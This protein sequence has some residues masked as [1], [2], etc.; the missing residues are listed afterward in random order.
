[1]RRL[2]IFLLFV[3]FPL[4][5]VAQYSNDW[6]SHNQTYYKISVAATGVY[7]V[8][9]DQLQAAGVP[10]NSIDPRLI[11]LFHRG[12]EQ[13]IY[14]KHNQQPADQ[15]FESGE[16][17]EFYGER[18]D[19]EMDA[20][21]YRPASAQ[22]NKYSNLYSDSSA[23]FLTVN[24]FPVQ[25]KRMESSDLVNTGIAKE[26]FHN[27]EQL[28]VYRNEYAIGDVRDT[29]LVQS[30]YDYGEGWTGRTI[31]TQNGNCVEQ[32][33]YTIT[34]LSNVVTTQ[35]SPVLEIQLTGRDYLGHQVEIYAGPSTANLNLVTTKQFVN[36]ETPVYTQQVPW[37]YVGSDGRMIVRVK[38]LGVGGFRDRLSVAYIKVSFAQGF[39]MNSATS[40][41]F[42]LNTNA[43]SGGKAYIELEN[44][45]SGTRLWDITDKQEIKTIALK[46]SGSL[47]SA[48]I[49]NT[50]AAR[51]LYAS[52]QFM[53]PA[54]SQIK[55]VTF[56][57]LNLA[58]KFI[59]VTHKSLQQP[60]GGYSNPVRAFAEYRASAA[61][62]GYDTLTVNVDQLYDQF[63]YG[64]LSPVGIYEFMRYMVDKGS[65]QYL[66]L[67]GRGRE[68]YD[69]LNRRTPGLNEMPDLVPPAGSPGADMPYTA[70]L[71]G[72]PTYVP[73]VATG[74]LTA[75][76]PQEV[77]SYLDKVKESE[78]APFDALWR[79]SL[80]HL[81]GG[82]EQ[83]QITLF[84]GYM[85]G[86][87]DIAR[88]DYLG[89]T[90]KTI[91]KKGISEVE[92]INVSSEVNAGIN[93]VTFFGHS[94]PNVTDIDIGF[95][96]DQVLGY[97]NK[98]KYPAF[99]VNGCNAGNYFT[100]TETFGENWT[101]TANKGA[102]NFIAN[103]SFGYEVPLWVYAT[104]FYRVGFADS[105]FLA[106][107]I[108]DVQREVARRIMIDFGDGKSVYSA[109][110]Q[111]MVLLGDPSL[112]LFAAARPD[113]ETRDALVDVVS[114]DGKPIHA[115]TDSIQVQVIVN[116]L[117]RTTKQELT[118][119]LTHSINDAATDYLV[120]YPSVRSQDT[121]KFTIVRAGN[122][123]GNNKIDVFLDPDNKID[124]LNED[125]NKASWS[126]V[127]QFNG[128]QNLQPGNFSIVNSTSI[129]ALFQDT[130]VL[131]PEKT[132]NIEFD[133]TR[134]FNSPF[135]KVTTVTGKVLLKT[136]FDLLTRDST[137]Y[138]WR[139]KPTDKTDDEWATTS[140]TYIHNG[141]E[142]WTQMAFDQLLENSWNRLTANET[143]KKFE[144]ES[145]NVSFTVRTFGNQNTEANLTPS[146]TIN[147]AEYYYSPTTPCRDN[148]IN[149]VAFDRS[150]VAPYAAVFF[151]FSNSGGRACGREP[152]V[153]NS[154][155]AAEVETGNDDDLFAYINNLKQSDSVLLFTVGDPGF[156]SWSPALKAKLEEIGVSVSDIDSFLPG[157][158]I[159]ILGK[160]SYSPGQAK[161]IRSTEANPEEQKL[162][163]SEELTGY[164]TSG[165]I[166]SVTIGPSLAWHNM[167]PAY[168]LAD[169][170]D[171]AG[172]DVVLVDRFGQE[173][174]YYVQQT[175]AIDL[176]EIDAKEYPYMRLVYRT[177]DESHLTPAPLKNWLVSYDP[178]PDGLLV[179]AS[180]ITALQLPE[181]VTQTTDFAFINISKIDFI[182]SLQSV[183]TILNRPTRTKETHEFKIKGPLAGDTT[184]FSQ[185]VSTLGKV[186][187]NDLS[188]RVNTGFVPEQYLQNNSIELSSYLEVLRDRQN[189][190]LEVTVDGR[191]VNDGDFV[192]ANPVIRISLRDDN[193]LLA[194]RDTTSLN[195]FITY[196]CAADNCPAK[197]LVFSRSDVTWKVSDGDLVVVF[198]PKDLEEGEYVLMANGTDIAGNPSGVEPY[199]VSFVVDKD[200]G[201][202]FY[203]PYPNPSAVGFYFDFAAVG[204]Q[205][206]D[207]FSLTIINRA[208]Q[209][210][211]HFTDQDAPALRVGLNQLH[212]TGL[213]AQGSR[214][215]DGLYFY[216]LT[217]TTGGNTYKNAGRIMIIR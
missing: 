47:L 43:G 205:A 189:P 146:L 210:I 204:E 169:E 87:A 190:V 101:L 181:G 197:R 14:F 83:S 8:T 79:K 124:E 215:S 46:G 140:F 200:P 60:A 175:T 111:Q 41:F 135:A 131:S 162:Q 50:S 110:V 137:V 193:Q 202:I 121:L 24:P 2:R 188:A 209:D 198:N 186:G 114:F 125:N 10:V 61:G 72:N 168:K 107:G 36:F 71:G 161:I 76:T 4:A 23:Y 155:K 165:S 214:L 206:P 52:S 118:V 113:F 115:L 66:F 160:K 203:S 94:A 104:Y 177:R 195:V 58:A 63:N 192:S 132:Y 106:K 122:F 108:G 138:Y 178:A 18:N 33:D 12:Q 139:T 15:N 96:D 64:E 88:G 194:I 7:R 185:T 130:D 11:Q 109:Q 35:A 54:I 31:C 128:T 145:T 22:P 176:S 30:F 98:G 68:V 81:S 136:H 158:P 56:R 159:I 173:T 13:A 48:V 40:R 16:Y 1:M 126:R 170:S 59:I 184:Y 6:V 208:G 129:D 20:K 150:T 112:R 212:W 213:D 37:S 123:Y 95:V 179:P 65:P 183:F 80:L 142:G 26:T 38:A 167:S 90:V 27:A 57:E 86:F 19:G 103:S 156:A 201:L 141:P 152:Q 39:N 171:E 85:E 51:K 82:K 151:D 75:V 143:K 180:A 211:A 153:I 21:M 28:R 187:F 74:R 100:N 49:E 154:F 174:V 97:N 149:L 34:Q 70:G 91:S 69:S 157:E 117:G 89:G 78:A 172:V 73:A 42:N 191:F 116:N 17:L 102:R 133:T 25:G 32:L 163:V 77:A 182:D 216:Q 144:F 67:I 148:T 99:L 44:A 3:L 134:S 55:Q 105:A 92:P 62:G 93:L 53:V 9:Y 207:S 166:T 5:S 127:I 196:P 45:P 217:V 120:R 164:A 119:K 29:Y 84:R 199:R 147:N